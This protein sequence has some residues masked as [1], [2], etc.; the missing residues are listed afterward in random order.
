MKVKH[1]ESGEQLV[2]THQGSQSLY[3]SFVPMNFEKNMPDNCAAFR[4][5][6]RSSTTSLQFYCILSAKRCPEQRITKWVTAKNDHLRKQV[7]HKYVVLILQLIAHHSF[8]K[9]E[10]FLQFLL[11][12]NTNLC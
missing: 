1:V 8:Q 3:T 4:C 11:S 6:N 10:F 7:T 5:T 9:Q 2:N 12:A